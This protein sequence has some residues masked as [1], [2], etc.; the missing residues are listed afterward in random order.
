MG[1]VDNKGATALAVTMTTSGGVNEANLAPL[2]PAELAVL[3]AGLPPRIESSAEDIAARLAARRNRLGAEGTQSGERVPDCN[4]PQS[5]GVFVPTSPPSD[6]VRPTFAAGE[7]V[8]AITNK[9]RA[10]PDHMIELPKGIAV[11]LLVG[12]EDAIQNLS[13]A[14]NRATTKKDKT[15]LTMGMQALV[16]PRDRLLR[17]IRGEAQ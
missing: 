16:G 14:H 4:N 12:I 10:A 1:E 17:L 8:E 3:A 13:Y 2:S 7:S 15:T 6:H 11:G 5:R 9:L